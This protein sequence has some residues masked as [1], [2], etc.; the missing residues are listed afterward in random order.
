[1]SSIIANNLDSLIY[2]GVTD[3][4]EESVKEHKFN[5][6]KIPAFAGM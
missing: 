6:K 1:M 3:N 2:I 4:K 5:L